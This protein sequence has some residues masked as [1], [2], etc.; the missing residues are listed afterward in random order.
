MKTLLWAAV[1]FLAVMWMLRGKVMASGA[2]F[3]WRTRSKRETLES[4]PMVQCV[5]CGVHL[6]ASEAF[7]AS[8]D[9]VFCSEEHRLRH[10]AR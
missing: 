7:T 6:P 3:F 5:H 1:C 10:A 8:T 2:D 9:A 4:E